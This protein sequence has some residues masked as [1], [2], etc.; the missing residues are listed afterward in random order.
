MKLRG[1]YH[2]AGILYDITIASR[3]PGGPDRK[4]AGVGLSRCVARPGDLGAKDSRYTSC[5]SVPN[6]ARASGPSWENNKE[7][8]RTLLQMAPG[9]KRAHS[10]N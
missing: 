1:T 7:V 3:S 9:N 2:H 5:T 4:V 6:A 8:V 10:G